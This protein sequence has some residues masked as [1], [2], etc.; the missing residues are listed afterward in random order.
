MK[1][2]VKSSIESA[3]SP[4]VFRNLRGY[5]LDPSLAQMLKDAPVSEI[6]FRVPWD[7]NLG[8]G[9]VD[10]YLEVIDFDPSARCFYEPVNLNDPHLLAADGLQPSEGTPQF[11]QQMVYAVA[12]LTIHNF[13]QA[14]G[15]RSLWA[16]GPS[17]RGRNRKNDSVFV[18]RLRVYPHALREANAY[19]SPAKIAL[20]FGYFNVPDDAIASATDHMPGSIVFTALSH[21]VV[22]HETAHALLDGMQRSLGMPT[23]EDM[24][25]FH[26]A[27]ADIVALF[28]H[29]TFPELMRHEIAKTRG[30]IDEQ[31]SELSR[32]A[33][34]FGKA[35]GSHGALR[36]F[37]GKRENGKWTR[38]DPD[39]G[40]IERTNEPHA[41]GA[42]LVSAIFEAFL[43][44]YRTR[45]A[46]LL[47]LY[48][49]GTGNLPEGDIHPDLVDRL[50][51]E[52]A[53]S[54]SH[55]LGICIRALDYC[56]PVDLTFGEYL[57]ALI[58]ADID[59]FPEDN[60]N[61]RV[62]FVEAFRRR[63]IY[64]R[65]VRTLSSE[66]LRWR[67]ATDEGESASKTLVRRLTSF[68]AQAEEHYYAVDRATLFVL[69][70]RDRKVLHDDLA[71]H[72][73]ASPKGKRDAAFLGLDP[74]RRFEVRS[75][76]FARRA[77]VL[78]RPMVQMIAQLI[79]P[80]SV[81]SPLTD[82]GRGR[83][84][85]F[86]GGVT[87]IAD[88]HSGKLA[89]CIRKPI[90]SSTRRRRQER[91]VADWTNQRLRSTYFTSGTGVDR[92]EPFAMLHRS[93]G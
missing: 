74:G 19:Y 47:R 77:G 23:N 20:L 61:Y 1:R 24:L 75:L 29:F 62:A 68:R 13:E 57:R 16:P 58:T 69:E 32:M 37:I 88:L 17:P 80:T 44:I 67:S 81:S 33:R 63:G 34:Q 56:P 14:L 5:A 15:R 27:F 30:G 93:R 8:P 10:E 84:M 66:N 65:D 26:E 50:S 36:E 72:F 71:K 7:N 82:L 40:L 52:A 42:I 38:A 53:R 2:R 64:P 85:A 45:V 91:Y 79:Q 18:Q 78:G 28:Q 4:P 12:R 73:K 55:V 60:H 11:H 6:I 35:I 21:D 76:H 43:A 70:R 54:A 48:T 90:G 39:A 25:A 86:E 89:Y 92:A 31:E 59:A 41:R 9:P 3:T 46:D 83:K 49:S 87:L 22:A 51:A